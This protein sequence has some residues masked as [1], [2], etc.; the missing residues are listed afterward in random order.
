[1]GV[2]S[3]MIVAAVVSLA[4]L[5]LH[6]QEANPAAPLQPAGA[7]TAEA[8]FAAAKEEIYLELNNL[9][10]I[11]SGGCR[12]T[13]IARNG[14]AEPIESLGVEVVVFDA[15][16]RVDQFLVLE[17]SRLMSGKTKAAQFDLANRP[18]TEISK[19]LVNDILNCGPVPAD[20]RSCTELARL[21]NRT[22]IEL[23]F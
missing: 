18:C 13:F 22:D 21:E 6:A 4:P 1:M 3:R 11:D 19:V 12:L 8:P 7:D 9:Q 17:F 16:Q 2:L 23:G 20:G 5:P 15:E 14:R 10:P